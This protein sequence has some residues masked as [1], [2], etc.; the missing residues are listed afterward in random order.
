MQKLS[1]EASELY[2]AFKKNYI[3]RGYFYGGSITP[4]LQNMETIKELEKANKIQRRKCERC[5]YEL[6]T[7]T[8]KE[9]ILNNKL[10]DVWQEKAPHFYP[11]STHGE[12]YYVLGYLVK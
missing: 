3:E 8:K 6:K 7:A 5:C 9:L 4:D 12:V 2:E 1:V 10:Y 11:N